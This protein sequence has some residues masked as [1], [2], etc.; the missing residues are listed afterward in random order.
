MPCLGGPILDGCVYNVSISGSGDSGGPCWGTTPQYALFFCFPLHK[1]SCLFKAL[2]QGY[3]EEYNRIYFPKI[4]LSLSAHKFVVVIV[5]AI[6]YSS[7]ALT[8]GFEV[9][10]RLLFP[11]MTFY[12]MSFLLLKKNSILWFPGSTSL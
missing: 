4:F 7:S 10:L 9:R 2:E 1:P 11:V 5:A 12:F 3:Q 6:E 8:M